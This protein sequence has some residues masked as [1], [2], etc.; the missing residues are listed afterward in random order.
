MAAAFTMHMHAD[1]QIYMG[2]H[3]SHLHCSTK[4]ELSKFEFKQHT[5]T[6]IWAVIM[7]MVD[8]DIVISPQT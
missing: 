8:H 5:S 2:M 7:I 3:A 6:L 1:L 4:L